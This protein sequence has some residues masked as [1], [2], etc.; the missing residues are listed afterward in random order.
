MV[1]TIDQ[2][3]LIVATVVTILRADIMRL[4]HP[5]HSVVS[6]SRAEDER[7]KVFP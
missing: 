6:I 1:K 7:Q 3:N 5:M 2:D 4:C